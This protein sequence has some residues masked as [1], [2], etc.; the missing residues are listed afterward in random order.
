MLKAWPIAGDAATGKAFLRMIRP[1]VF[2]SFK[3]RDGGSEIIE[4]VKRIKD[5]IDEKMADRGHERERE[6]RHRRH[7]RD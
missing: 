1:L 7:P 3:E 6:A 4:Q 5:M 2:G